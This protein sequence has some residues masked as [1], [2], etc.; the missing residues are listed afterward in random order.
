MTIDLHRQLRDY[1]AALEEA[2]AAIIWAEV[3]AR[4]GVVVGEMPT[5]RRRIPALKHPALVA[6]TAILI[7]LVAGGLMLGIARWLS[8]GDSTF[9]DEPPVTT[10]APAVTSTTEVTIT[11]TAVTTTGMPDA[12]TFAME[13]VA[14]GSWAEGGWTSSVAMG[15]PGLVVG[16]ADDGSYFTDAAVWT[17]TDGDTWLR[18]GD[19]PA[20]FGDES[21]ADGIDGNQVIIDLASGSL[22]VVA[23]GADGKPGDYDA[24]VWIS[25]DGLVWERVPHDEEVFGGEG[26]QVMLS[27][28]QT[29]NAAVIVGKSGEHATVWVSN[30]GREWTRALIDGSSDGIGSEPSAMSDVA[31]GGPGLVAVGGAGFESRPAV[32]LSADGTMW[33]RLPDPLGGGAT[34]V[35]DGGL[36][37]NPVTLV[38]AGES[39]LVAIGP[40]TAGPVVW[41]S[42]D[43]FGW[44]MLD[45]TFLDAPTATHAV[46]EDVV[47]DG[48]LL[49][50]VGRF[51]GF[52]FWP[53]LVAMWVSVDGGM[54]WQVGSEQEASPE[55][56]TAGVSYTA[57]P[58]PPPAI[59]LTRFGSTFIVV[60][61][62][63]IPTGESIN[64]YAQYA[65]T[66]AIWVVHLD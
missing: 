8:G 62:D 38:A 63:S 59:H 34:G 46:V 21:S 60:G 50:A 56:E 10:V 40:S 27:V 14:D 61:S 58:I 25:A 36:T 18:V 11:T 33:S 42:I 57:L 30:D 9:V 5:G 12:T 64:G 43:G 53:G 47:W 45:A 31:L 15:G 13:R 48:D 26:D 54:T 35:E 29:E 65:R 37:V 19:D 17:S 52:Q 28:V 41:T 1:G 20:V 55:V 39:G 4:V 6:G 22:G 2:Q 7:V 16:G 3:A 23:V 66:A 51:E 49:I 24:A 32:W 44:H